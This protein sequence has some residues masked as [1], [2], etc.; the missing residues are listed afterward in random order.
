MKAPGANTSK[1]T[2]R[3]AWSLVISPM[4]WCHQ[5]PWNFRVRPFF[6]QSQSF[7]ADHP[8]CYYIQCLS[9][10]GK[11]TWAMK[12]WSSSSCASVQATSRSVP[13]SKTKWIHSQCYVYSY[14]LHSLTPSG[15]PSVCWLSFVV[16]Q[17]GTSVLQFKVHYQHHLCAADNS[18]CQPQVSTMWDAQVLQQGSNCPEFNSCN[19]GHHIQQ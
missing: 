13:Y 5:W 19:F 7:C 10:F 9:A 6:T 16:A 8:P 18:Y 11:H 4:S 2:S 3:L 14:F 1:P 15:L 17:V 12:S